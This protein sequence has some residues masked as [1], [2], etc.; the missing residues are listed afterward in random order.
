[1]PSTVSTTEFVIEVLT[2][3]SRTNLIIHQKLKELFIDN[4]SVPEFF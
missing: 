2:I 4:I 3:W 1:M